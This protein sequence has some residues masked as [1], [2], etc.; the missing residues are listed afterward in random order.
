[1]RGNKLTAWHVPPMWSQFERGE[2]IAV[3]YGAAVVREQRRLFSSTRATLA[4]IAED[5]CQGLG[6]TVGVK[7]TLVITHRAAMRLELP[8]ATDTNTIARA[9]DMENVE[10]WCDER[11][12]VHVGIDPWYS[13]KD[14]DQVVL[15]VTKVVHV[16]LGIHASDQD[17]A[18]GQNFGQRLIASMAEILLLQ[19]KFSQKK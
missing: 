2:K 5:V 15:S 17:A 8:P 1:M 10:A 7:S 14:V 6:E 13:M 9:I 19:K 16:L 11:G 4:A 12:I 18:R 3:P